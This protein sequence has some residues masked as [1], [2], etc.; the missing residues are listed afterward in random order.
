MKTFFASIALFLI[1][2]AI[3]LGNTVYISNTVADL[4]YRIDTLP[5]CDKA[6][7][8][9]LELEALWMKHRRRIGLSI[10]SDIIDQMQQHL[11]QM[12]TA[13]A[14]ADT[15]TFELN[16]ALAQSA[17]R[18]IGEAEQITFENLL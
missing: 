8:A 16:R 14:L 7:M 18:R 17:L 11:V 15:V 4:L 5:P 1:L 2:L 3:I 12:K 10:S 13:S 9:L 6:G